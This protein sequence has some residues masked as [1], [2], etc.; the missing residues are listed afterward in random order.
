MVPEHI[1]RS[2]DLYDMGTEHPLRDLVFSCLENTPQERPDAGGIVEFLTS[3]MLPDKIDVPSPDSSYESVAEQRS[4]NLSTTPISVKRIQTRGYDYGFKVV[5]LGIPGVGKTS[6]IKRFLHPEMEMRRFKTTID[7]GD[8]FERL[9]IR[10]KTV[11]L[12]IVDTPG[13][14]KSLHHSTSSTI[15][16][17]YRKVNGVALVYDV[18]CRLSF[19]QLS[20]WL[21]IVRVSMTSLR[22]YK[23]YV[24]NIK[25]YP[26][27]HTLFSPIETVLS[28]AQGKCRLG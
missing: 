10:G 18:G 20:E 28:A 8:Y 7:P 24:I 22:I 23:A 14:V 11:H 9:Q 15:P 17:I 6:I 19:Q 26:D 13:E 2:K 1:R 27:M 25:S 5:V 4:L 16:I 21:Q 3:F 12:H